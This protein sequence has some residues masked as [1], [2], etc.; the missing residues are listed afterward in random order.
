MEIL[1]AGL[2]AGNFGLAIALFVAHVAKYD[3]EY[4][5]QARE[6]DNYKTYFRTGQRPDDRDH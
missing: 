6:D 3:R 5:R 4:A 2:I 1:V